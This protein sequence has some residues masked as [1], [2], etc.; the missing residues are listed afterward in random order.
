MGPVLAFQ[1]RP[2]VGTA[3]SS[4]ERRHLQET[5]VTNHSKNPPNSNVIQCTL[6]LARMSRM[7][8]MMSPP[9]GVNVVPFCVLGELRL[10]LNFGIFEGEGCF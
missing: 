9:D 1:G 10:M 2:F 5:D 7:S 3:R 6:F 4:M 8:G